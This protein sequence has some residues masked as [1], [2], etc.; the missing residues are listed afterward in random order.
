MIGLVDC[1]NF[2]ASCERTFNPKLEG[3]P[4]GIL[5]NNDGCV[6]ARSNELKPLVPMG[7]PA[8]QISPAIRKQITLLSSNYE[9][10]GDMSRRVFDT[11][12]Q[13]TADVALYSIDE[14]FIQLAGFKDV[15][16]H[17]QMLK[18][19]IKRDTGIP[20]SIGISSTRTLAKLANHLAKKQV[21]YQGVCY[22]PHNDPLLIKVLQ[23]FP[24]SEIWGVG[25]RIAEKLQILGINTA[26]ELRQANTKHIRQQFSVML[27]RTVLELQG[28]PCTELDDLPVTK[29]TIMTSRSFGQLTGE[30]FDLQE[31]IRIHASRGAEKLRHQGSIACAV[32]V[33]LKTNRFHQELTQYN[34]SIIVPLSSPS[35][36]SR[37]IIQAA[38]KGLQAIYKKGILFMKAGVML[39][40]LKPKGS[41]IQGDLFVT[42]STTMQEQKSDKLMQTIDAI[43]QKMG[44]NTLQLGG[45]RKEAPWQIKRECLS[46]RY[47]TRWDELLKVK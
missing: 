47:T 38:Q 3:Q 30:L 36:D 17:C 23:Q 26:W 16:A 24:V 8:Y 9:L 28:I 27:E 11:L 19:I 43:N 14:A 32:L 29:Q 42:S 20:V 4:I 13:H 2:Y 44:K 35:D 25:R 6:I 21:I 33:F 18:A 37:L 45:I 46:Q 41:Q 12:R 7:M 15:S 39:L 22:L 31:A 10:Y 40:D 5:S 1:N 34:P